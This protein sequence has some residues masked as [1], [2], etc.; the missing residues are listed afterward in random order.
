VKI[1][2]GKIKFDI[3]E[4]S[5]TAKIRQSKNLLSYSQFV[6]TYDKKTSYITVV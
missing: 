6:G 5:L 3:A 2:G 1:N 4:M